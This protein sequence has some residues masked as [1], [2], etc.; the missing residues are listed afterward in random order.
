M[1]A[2]SDEGRRKSKVERVIDSYGLTGF[3][4]TL[5]ERWTAPEDSDSLRDLATLLNEK[6]IQ[7]AL[8]ETD[9]E[10]LKGEAE[11]LYSLLSDDDTTEGMRVQAKNSLESRGV[12]V[13]QLSSDF[14][15]HQAVYTYLTEIRGVSKDSESKNRIQSVVDSVQKL[16]GRLL[17]VTERSL[18]SLRDTNQLRLGDFDVL[19]DTQ[20]YCRDCGTQYEVIQLL[21]RGGCECGTNSESGRQ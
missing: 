8:R 6:M 19:I 21:T 3:G 1:G 14:V 7:S 20:V 18:E 15:S 13:D 4:E 17:A 10:V 9:S 11:N 16:R 12:D 5:A 2:N